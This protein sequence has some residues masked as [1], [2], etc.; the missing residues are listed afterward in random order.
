M[1]AIDIQLLGR[2]ARAALASGQ[3]YPFCRVVPLL[4]AASGNTAKWVTGYLESLVR[5]GL[6]AEAHRLIEQ[7]PADFQNDAAVAGFVERIRSSPSRR[8]AWSSR[9]RRYEAN[10]QALSQIDPNLADMVREA[11]NRASSAYELHLCSDGNVQVKRSDVLWP[12]Q[13]LPSLDDHRTYAP[14]RVDTTVDGILP[15]PLLFDGVG[16]GW[17]ILAGYRATRKVFLESSSA[18]YIVEQHPEAVGIAFHIHD[19]RE[20]LADDRVRWFVGPQASEDLAA[21]LRSDTGWP[22]SVRICSCGLLGDPSRDLLTSVMQSTHGE[23][24]RHADA[25]REKIADRYVGRD[26]AYWADRFAASMDDGGRPLRI[27]GVTSIHTTFLKHSMRDCLSALEQLGHETR[28]V[29]EP[30]HHRTLDPTITL[31]A[32]L[33][34]EPDVVLLL[35]RMRYEMPNLVHPD[36]PSVTWDQDALPWVFDAKKKPTL[37][38]ND[39]LMGF[40]AATAGQ[41]FGWPADRL[42]HCAMAGGADIYSPVALTEDSLAP[43][44]SDVS[45]VSHASATVEEESEHAMKWLPEGRLRDLFQS[46]VRRVIPEWLRGAVFPGSVMPVVVDTAAELGVRLSRDEAF[47]VFDALLRVGDRVFRHV[48]LEWVADWA[49]RTGRTFHLWGN[50]W[51]RHPR[52]GRYARGATGNGEELRCVYQA[53]A[54]NLQLMG[55]GFIHQRALDGLMASGFFMTRR[56]QAD[57]QGP[58][59][60]ELVDLFDACGISDSAGLAALG[61][62][63]RAERIRTLLSD[64]G[65]DPRVLDARVVNSWRCGLLLPTA[66]EIIPGFQDISFTSAQEFEVQAERFLADPDLRGRYAS[67]MRAVLMERYSYRSRMGQMIEFLER[68]FRAQAGR[69]GSCTDRV[70]E[71]CSF[72]VVIT[73]SGREMGEDSRFSCR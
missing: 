70:T 45:Y 52:L 64:F 43:F 34:F 56:S 5:L 23:R 24:V 53:S 9:K 12:P 2:L 30:D 10:L 67:Q 39:F 26:A 32:Q 63:E 35:S 6:N 1:A 72:G 18:I 61:A 28:I 54:I 55:Y 16:L 7:F 59:L 11:W 3:P 50:G 14:E 46:V 29:I 71:A 57:V 17:E 58:A 49:D 22:L 60:R 38:W 36:I 66:D 44:R 48:A 40:S 19:W 65:A 15:P 62:D 21:L 33:D 13:W 41:R 42:M 31:Q 51:D 47:Q 69:I 20:I 73:G 25:L 8:I 27:M 4:A 68:G 37:A